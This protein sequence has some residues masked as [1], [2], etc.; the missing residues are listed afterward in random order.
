MKMFK[1]GLGEGSTFACCHPAVNLMYFVFTIGITMFSTGPAFLAETLVFSWTYSI[2]LNGKKAIKTNIIFTVPVL[3]IMTVINTF[4][5]HNGATVLFYLNYGRITLEALLYGLAAAVLLSSVIVWFSCFNVIMSSDKLIYFFG[6]IAPVLGLTLSM[7]FR[8]IPLLKSRYKEISMGQRCM[9]RHQKGSYLS[10]L[11]QTAKEVSILI[12]WSLE[13]A[14][15]TSDSMEARGYGLPG[16]TSF[17]LFK[18]TQ[19]DKMLLAAMGLCGGIAAIGCALGKTSIYYYPVV[20]LTN[21][22][23]MTVVTFIAYTALLMIPLMIDIIGELKWQQ[24][25]LKI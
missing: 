5:T 3:I 24:Y 1:N 14:I 8:F 21:W 19:T 12:S 7:I 15:E 4:F 23:L 6:K 18:L 11:R 17:H 16:R 25:E 13:A 10:K 22:D 20:V 9:G 2:L